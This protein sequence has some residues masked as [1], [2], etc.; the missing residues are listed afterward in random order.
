L[1]A[2]TLK[3]Y[4]A[5]VKSRLTQSL[6]KDIVESLGFEVNRQS[7]FMMREEQTPSA[8]ISSN[9]YIKDFGGDFAGDTI[10]FVQYH[11]NCS[12]VEAINLVAPFVSMEPFNQEESSNIP[13]PLPKPLIKEIPKPTYNLEAIKHNHKADYTPELG[14]QGLQELYPCITSVD[15]VEQFLGWSKYYNSLTIELQG[16]TTVRRA[17]ETKWKTFGS[18]QYIPFKINLHDKYVYLYSGMAEII[19]MEKMGL[20][21]IGL[22]SDSVDKSITQEI[23]DA[24]KGKIL[25]VIQEN[26][27][28][29]RKLSQRITK[30]FDNVKIIDMATLANKKN[31]KGYDLRDFINDMESFEAVKKIL[32]AATNITEIEGVESKTKK[33]IVIPYKSKYIS[34]QNDLN[35]G[36]L[37]RGVI[38]AVTGSGKTHAF[39]NKPSTLILV[40]RVLQTTVATGEDSNYLIDTIFEKGA[41]ITYEKFYGH[42]FGNLAFREFVDKKKIRVIVDEAHMLVRNQR[43]EYQL[44]YGL[45][46][47]FLSGTLDA[48]FREDL[49]RYKFKPR[50]PLKMYYTDG[51]VPEFKNALYFVDKAKALMSNYP[52]NCIV[53][54]EHKFNNFDIHEYV[55]GQVFATSASREGVSMNRDTFDAIIVDAANCSSWW[56]KDIIQALQRIRSDK[57]IRI[58]TK[59]IINQKYRHLTIKHFLD[60]A[61]QQS[62]SKE[63]NTIAGEFYSKLI[64]Y[65]HKMTGYT[66]ATEY[67]VACFLADLTKDYYDPD[68]YSFEPYEGTIKE[69]KINTKTKK[70]NSNISENNTINIVIDGVACTVPA[71]N[72]RNVERWKFLFEAGT[73]NRFAKYTE[74]TSFEWLWNQSSIVHQI[75]ANYNKLNPTK[76][77]NRDMLL[78]ILRASVRVEFYD[79]D[80]NLVQ[81]ITDKNRRSLFFKVVSSNPFGV[82]GD[83]R[84]YNTYN[85]NALNTSDKAYNLGALEEFNSVSKTCSK[86]NEN[87]EENSTENEL[88]YTEKVIK[89]EV[90]FEQEDESE[91]TIRF[92]SYK[93]V[94][95][96]YLEEEYG[97]R[98]IAIDSIKD[99]LV[100]FF[101]DDLDKVSFRSENFVKLLQ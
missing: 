20:S 41:I 88:Q 11:N 57:V 92:N 31:I 96:F 52:N 100:T 61:E 97:D 87:K 69:F 83:L 46:A 59:P 48:A 47:V 28:S 4:I 33:E 12:F 82:E 74:L 14:L 98:F 67:G 1:L 55:A 18:K 53:G 50:T 77:F 75:R 45:D 29:S 5:N 37:E 51:K 85:T 9:G 64:E 2:E 101:I 25:V 27:E 35:I 66:H 91:E 99:D 62:E 95:S 44:I 71:S 90:I 23:I 17:G 42:Y 8:S 79:S 86:S 3:N 89:N 80:N 13:K 16:V 93:K 94:V 32:N 76:K 60:I 84:L 22:Q 38:I 7:K 65:T 19:A 49:Q 36:S 73:V 24:T 54:A 63:L 70:E 40:P 56:V 68:L 72:T 30:I 21:Y 34:S 81:R 78:K 43:K 39:E 10:S 26:D 6:T 58:V 15:G